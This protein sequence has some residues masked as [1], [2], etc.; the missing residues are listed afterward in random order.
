MEYSKIHTH[1]FDD[2]EKDDKIRLFCLP[3]AGGGASIFRKWS[4]VLP[5]DVGTNGKAILDV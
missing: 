5:C 4:K 2:P 1:F 3:Y